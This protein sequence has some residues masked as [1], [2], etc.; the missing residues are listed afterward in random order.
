MVF[1]LTVIV[2]FFLMFIGALFTG[3]IYELTYKL[4]II[5]IISCFNVTVPDI[6][7]TLFVLL[8]LGITACTYKVSTDKESYTIRDPKFWGKWFGGIMA[9]LLL[10]L[11]L[12]IVNSFTIG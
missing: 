4:A 2:G 12:W 1:I 5:P 6:P 11:L 9:K 3:W 7:F 8:S 10:I